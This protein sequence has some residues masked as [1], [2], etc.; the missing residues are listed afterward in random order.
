MYLD[1][2]N[3]TSLRGDNDRLTQLFNNHN[4]TNHFK[5]QFRHVPEKKQIPLFRLYF[6]AFPYEHFHMS[7]ALNTSPTSGIVFIC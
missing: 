1:L 4:I 5:S 3:L 6:A 2:L 7:T